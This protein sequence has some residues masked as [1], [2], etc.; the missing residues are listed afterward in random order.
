MK[1]I[2]VVPLS[3]IGFWLNATSSPRPTE[4]EGTAL[5]MKNKR[6]SA[7]AHRSA[8]ARNATPPRRR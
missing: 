6:P 2:A 1:T 8:R 3:R 5:G 4:T 7:P